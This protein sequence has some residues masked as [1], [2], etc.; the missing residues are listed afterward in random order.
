MVLSCCEPVDMFE[1]LAS[2]CGEAV[3]DVRAGF[4]RVL[5]AR[6]IDC[7]LPLKGL[8]HSE[9]VGAQKAFDCFVVAADQRGRFEADFDPALATA[10]GDAGFPGD[11]L[12]AA[13]FALSD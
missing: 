8:E 10:R 3:K 5:A 6:E 4:E 9:V 11:E 12:P 13:P 2:G 7:E 1:P